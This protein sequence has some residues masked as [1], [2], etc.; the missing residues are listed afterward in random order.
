MFMSVETL[1]SCMCVCCVFTS[2]HRDGFVC[3]GLEFQEDKST[4]LCWRRFFPL[5]CLAT[6]VWNSEPFYLA[7]LS[8]S[9]TRSGQNHDLT[10][11]M[12]VSFAKTWGL[13]LPLSGIAFGSRYIVSRS[14]YCVI[15]LERGRNPTRKSESNY[16]LSIEPSAWQST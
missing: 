7:T 5:S 14:T 10:S 13:Q 2:I 6:L 3:L 4:M 15:T 12:C 8:C 1:L 11:F 16:N 9:H